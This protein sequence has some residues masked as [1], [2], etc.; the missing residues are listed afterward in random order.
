MLK[1]S[2]DWNKC[3]DRCTEVKL[4]ALVGN[5]DRPNNRPTHRPNNEPTDATDG[6]I[7]SKW[8]FTSNELKWK[9]KSH[10]QFPGL[11]P[12]M[13]PPYTN[14]KNYYW[15]GKYPSN[16][17]P[18]EGVGNR[19]VIYHKIVYDDWYSFVQTIAT[20]GS[21]EIYKHVEKLTMNVRYKISKHQDGKRKKSHIIVKK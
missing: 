19:D 16:E 4:P 15:Q 10:P 13:Q 5:Y 17:W 14:Q 20:D 2:S 11:P 21:S 12:H 8:S 7:G 1:Q 3:C 18:K 6:Q 9:L